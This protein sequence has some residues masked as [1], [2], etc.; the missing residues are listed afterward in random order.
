MYK[1]KLC[2]NTEKF[3]GFAKEK[4]NALIYQISDKSSFW[5]YNISDNSWKSAFKP[6]KCFY[7]GSK[8]IIN[9]F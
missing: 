3:I 5:I 9:I 2:G 4:G 7:C 8:K 6:L 1:C